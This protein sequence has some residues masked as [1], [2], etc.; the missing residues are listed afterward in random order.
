MAVYLGGLAITWLLLSTQVLLPLILPAD[1]S[2]VILTT[3][4]TG[5]LSMSERF[6]EPSHLG[7]V[8]VIL[9]SSGFLPLR[10]RLTLV[11]GV[12]LAAI[13]L[14]RHVLTA[15]LVHLTM[16]WAVAAFAEVHVATMQHSARRTTLLV[17]ALS[18][19]MCSRFAPDGARPSIQDATD[20]ATVTAWSPSPR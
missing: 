8:L 4:L 6:T 16:P 1:Y 12:G 13:L 17:L 15:N 14:N 18:Q 2:S 7:A 5:G 19:F 20:S 3:N 11:G 9:A 10:S